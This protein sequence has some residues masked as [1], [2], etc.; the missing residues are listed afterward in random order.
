MD[1]WDDLVS[2]WVVDLEA[3][4][5][6]EVHDPL[7]RPWLEEVFDSHGSAPAWYVEKLAAQRQ[8]DLVAEL[9]P[10]VL[11]QAEAE[12]GHRPEMPVDGDTVGHDQIWAVTRELA[13]VSIADAIQSLI[14][15]R[16]RVIWPVS[17]FHPAVTS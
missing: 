7:V 15:S 11:D 16:D 17:P 1:R 4:L 6:P 5:G 9:V 10:A 2:S 13:L 8:Q 14:A 12:L 3:A